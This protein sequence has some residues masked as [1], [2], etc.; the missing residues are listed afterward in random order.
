MYALV[1]QST[2]FSH[3]WWVQWN[4]LGLN[5]KTQCN[6]TVT[7]EGLQVTFGY[8]QNWDESSYLWQLFCRFSI[9]SFR[10][11]EYIRR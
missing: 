4:F 10:S 11:S 3:P 2:R 5:W 1:K 6:R 8:E 7:L 9:Y